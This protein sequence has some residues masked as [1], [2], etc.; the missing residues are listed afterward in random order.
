MEAVECPYCGEINHTSNPKVMAECAYCGSRFAEVREP[1]R[2]LII[3]DGAVPGS[4]ER[5]EELMSEWQEKCDLEKEAIVDRRLGEDEIEWPE[6][7]FCPSGAP[8]PLQMA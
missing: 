5:A 6:R 2:T 4:W 7:R 1:Y 3:L 8:R